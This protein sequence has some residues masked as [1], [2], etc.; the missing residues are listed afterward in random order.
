MIDFVSYLKGTGINTGSRP[1]SLGVTQPI[2]YTVRSVNKRALVAFGM[3]TSARGPCVRAFVIVLRR[4]RRMHS[5]NIHSFFTDFFTALKAST[6]SGLVICRF[7][8]LESLAIRSGASKASEKPLLRWTLSV[9]N[10]LFGDCMS[11]AMAT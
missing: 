1:F 6:A 7:S 10:L 9:V 3:I 4:V 11:S 8:L 5:S 2:G